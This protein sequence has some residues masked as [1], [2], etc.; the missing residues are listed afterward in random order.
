MARFSQRLCAWLVLL[1]LGGCGSAQPPKGAPA[2]ANSPDAK[3]QLNHLVERYW[4]ERIPARA[5]ISPQVLADS[6][7]VERRYLSEAMAV[8][9]DALDAKSRLTY[10][11]FRRQRELLVEGFTYPRELMPLGSFSGVLQ[12][13]EMLSADSAQRPWS[14]GDYEY[15]LKRVNEYVNWTQ[16]A[17]LNMRE[18]V[19]RGYVSPRCVIERGLVLLQR[20]AEDSSASVFRLP[21]RSMPDSIGEPERTRLKNLIASAV[22]VQL[23]PANRTL[24]DY[25]QHEYLPHGRVAIGLS[26]LPLGEKWYGYEI[27]RATDT[28]LAPAEIHAIGVAE[29]ERLR[30]RLVPDHE[31]AQPTALTVEE[32]QKAY[33]ELIPQVGSALLPLFT[34]PPDAPL[35]VRGTEWLADPKMALLYVPGGLPGGLPGKPAPV[36]Y[37]NIAPAVLRTGR[38]SMASFLQQALPGRHLQAALAQERVDLPRFRRMEADAGF[39]EGWGLYAA[40]LGEQLGL[41]AD[42]TAKTEALTLQLQCAAG[43][44]VDTGLHAKGWTRKQALDY[45][46]AQLTIDDAG[47]QVLVDSYAANPADALACKMGELRFVSLRTKAQQALGGRFDIR[48]FHTEILRDGAMPLDLLEAK[49]KIWMDAAR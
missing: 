40:S 25:L 29:V 13:I 45:L 32:L 20:P 30:L 42:D 21:L 6:L 47:A 1:V 4:D 2:A 16:Q 24:H 9:R 49:M 44:V 11:V 15:W 12:S 33:Q 41:L 27:K 37:F 28:T 23:A 26:V 35:E 19:R 18:G 36:L 43:L 10:D 17:V 7:A 46:R 48:A 34:E 14:I 22:D 8:P 3:E 38:V 5:V 39:V 31:A